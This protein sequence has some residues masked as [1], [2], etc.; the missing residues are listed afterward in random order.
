MK[1]TF[2]FISIF[3]ILIFF[4]TSGNAQSFTIP[5]NE[6][7]FYL[8]IDK[9]QI[10]R[11]DSTSFTAI[12]LKSKGFKK[13]KSEVSIASPLPN[14]IQINFTENNAVFDQTIGKLFVSKDAKPGKISLVI[15]AEMRY[16]KKGYFLTIE[17]I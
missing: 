2:K 13:S 3:T 6:F 14:G 5:H 8:P 17:V 12:L 10:R 9:I 4:A 15:S 11:G 7:T 1:S 16:L